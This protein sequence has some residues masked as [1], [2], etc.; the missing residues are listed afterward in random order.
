MARGG[1]SNI[2]VVV[3]DQFWEKGIQQDVELIF[4]KNIDG[5]YTPEPEFDITQ[6]ANNNFTSVFKSQR[7]IL[8]IKIDPNTQK[9]GVFE[10]VVGTA[11]NQKYI[12][13]IGRGLSEISNLLYSKQNDL[14]QHYNQKRLTALQEQYKEERSFPT[15]E[16]M[17]KKYGFTIDIPKD[18]NL[19]NLED[20]FVYFSKQGK[21]E[22]DRGIRK[23]CYYQKGIFIHHYPYNGP[24]DF[25]LK[26]ILQ[27]RDSITKIYLLGPDRAKKT[28]MEY[29]KD[30]PIY[31]QTTSV[32]NSY[33]ME[34]K[35]WWNMVNATMG[36]PFVHYTFLDQ[37][38]NRVIMIDG[39][40]FAPNFNKRR[41]IKQ[42][43]ALSKTIE[44][45]D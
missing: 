14:F 25:E 6:I 32:L 40:V 13:I 5:L 27:K 7:M 45:Y 28:Y 44:I 26:N 15:M 8:E 2:I 41:F 42:L 11:R 29:E 9:T 1:Y 30:F 24:K 33:A 20:N 18:Y 23:Q 10:P 36:G 37:K 43:E 12:K 17:R 4:A 22:C 19:I 31:Q 34:L 16:K 35:G 3:E 38:N 39:Y 21:L